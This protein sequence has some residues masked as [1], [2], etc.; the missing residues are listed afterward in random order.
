VVGAFA[1]KS[2]G[3]V[4]RAQQGIFASKE[5]RGFRALPNVVAACHH[6]HPA[7][8]QGLK[9]SFTNAKATLR[10]LAVRNNEIG[11]RFLDK[12]GQVCKNGPQTGRAD[13]ISQHNYRSW[14]FRQRGTPTTRAST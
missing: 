12:R 4:G 6:I 2:F 7:A 5:L 1:R 14:C 13:N 11:V 3:I 9:L 10:V 8:K